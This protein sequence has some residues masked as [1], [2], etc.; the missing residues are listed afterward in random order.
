MTLSQ[1]LDLDYATNEVEGRRAAAARFRLQR[2]L[3][4]C[5]TSSCTP[6]VVGLKPVNGMP[7]LV[8]CPA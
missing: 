2:A 4:R 5:A 8:C 1:F 3:R 7:T 6:T